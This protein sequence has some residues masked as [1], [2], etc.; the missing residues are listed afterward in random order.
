MGIHPRLSLPILLTILT[1]QLFRISLASQSP[2]TQNDTIIS[3]LT[4][5]NEGQF[6][7]QPMMVTT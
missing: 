5:Q 1:L 2:L 3:P 6:Q 7:Y 4:D